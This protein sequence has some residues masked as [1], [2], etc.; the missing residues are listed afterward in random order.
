[1]VEFIEEAPKEEKIKFIKDA[2]DETKDAFTAYLDE[3]VAQKVTDANDVKARYRHL[4]AVFCLAVLFVICISGLIVLFS[5]LMSH[6]PVNLKALLLVSIL[7]LSSLLWPIYQYK[8]QPKE[9]IFSVLLQFYG[10]WQK[11]SDHYGTAL[12][13]AVLPPHQMAQKTHV[14]KG[15]YGY[16]DIEISDV[17]LEN[18]THKI[19]GS[20]V[21]MQFVLPQSTQQNMLLLE[22]NAFQ[23]KT[24]YA[25]MEN[26]TDQVDFSVAK[27]FTIFS[28]TD[29]PW[30]EFLTADILETALDLKDSTDAHKIYVAIKENEVFVFLDKCSTLYIENYQLF[31]HNVDMTSYQKFNYQLTSAFLLIKVITDRLLRN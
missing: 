9:D 12:E 15:K 18:D 7:A 4:F 19:I 30:Q 3:N 17:L 27:Y 5:A 6:H 1:M 8:K 26:I 31:G 16:T 25:N 2:P 13:T 10:D 24:D 21:I 23:K 29:K 28:E 14:I 11:V 20:G 22:K